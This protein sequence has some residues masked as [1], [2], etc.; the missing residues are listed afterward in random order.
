M[1]ADIRKTSSGRVDKALCVVVCCDTML[2]ASC[3]ALAMVNKQYLCRWRD[4]GGCARQ[5]GLQFGVNGS[6]VG[7]LCG[8]GANRISRRCVARRVSWRCVGRRP[9]AARPSTVPRN[10]SLHPPFPR[11]RRRTSN[12]DT[13][14]L[15]SATL[16]STLPRRPHLHRVDAYTLAE[17]TPPRKLRARRSPS[18]V[19]VCRRLRTSSWSMYCRRLVL[20]LVVGEHAASVFHQRHQHLQAAQ[21]DVGQHA[22]TL[23]TSPAGR[24]FFASRIHLPSCCTPL[25]R[26]KLLCVGARDVIS[27]QIPRR[28]AAASIR[29]PCRLPQR[30]LSIL[31]FWEAT[32]LASE[33]GHQS[34]RDCAEVARVPP[35]TRH[36]NQRQSG[37]SVAGG[38]PLLPFVSPFFG[39]SFIISLIWTPNFFPPKKKVD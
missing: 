27:T 35:S 39:L 3:E 37:R 17:T 21:R 36:T 25:L 33:H 26:H 16:Y 2:C 6:G 24:W 19:R 12:D 30:T 18:R 38:A 15:R 8:G 29:R 20:Q 9:S 1:K 34:T 14:T 4:S 23:A 13:R 31:E 22:P 11:R 5:A 7:M 10:P 32:P 28:R